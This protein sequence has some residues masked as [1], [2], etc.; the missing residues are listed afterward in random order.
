MGVSVWP[1]EIISAVELT[2][3]RE[4][5]RMVN[6]QQLIFLHMAVVFA[7]FVCFSRLV[8]LKCS[9]HISARVLGFVHRTSAV[10]QG[11]LATDGVHLH[12]CHIPS[13]C[14][15][16]KLGLELPDCMLCVMI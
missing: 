12:G 10:Q 15:A 8:T 2:V 5:A 9:L 4:A 14:K 3:E 1:E 11:H 13:S 6:W 7:M 16:R